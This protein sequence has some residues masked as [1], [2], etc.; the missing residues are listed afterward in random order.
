MRDTFTRV[1]L[2][3]LNGTDRDASRMEP[4]ISFH[5][6]PSP[7]LILIEIAVL[8]FFLFLRRM[9]GSMWRRGKA[10]RNGSRRAAM[11][12]QVGRD[13]RR[14][15]GCGERRTSFIRV[16]VPGECVFSI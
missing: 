9:D 6:I 1:N 8:P 7:L 11:V 3:I 4:F 10:T 14:V 2:E 15:S 12:G 5:H 16:S 13:P